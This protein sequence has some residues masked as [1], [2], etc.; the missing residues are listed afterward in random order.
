MVAVYDAT[1]LLPISQNLAK[2]YRQIG[3]NF[4]RQF[5]VFRL[6]GD[7]Q[8]DICQHN[9]RQAAA[10]GREDLMGMWKLVEQCIRAPGPMKII[11]KTDARIKNFARL[12]RLDESKVP[13]AIEA[14][15]A[16]DIPW[17]SH[18]FGRE[19]VNRLW[20]WMQNPDLILNKKD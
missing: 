18:P 2:L 14:Y 19:L 8:L 12:Y 10:E 13:R 15:T 16:L 1:T 4:I 20:V 7:S 5:R 9:F 6:L 3:I 11:P 17:A